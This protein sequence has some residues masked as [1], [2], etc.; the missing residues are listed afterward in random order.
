MALRLVRATSGGVGSVSPELS[1]VDPALA[2][3]VRGTPDAVVVGAAAETPDWHGAAR[4]ATP[5]TTTYDTRDLLLERHGLR[6][7]LVSDGPTRTWR[8]TAARGEVVETTSAGPGVPPEI[9]SLLTN[10]VVGAQLVRVPTRSID[11]DIRRLEDSIAQQ[12]HALVRHDVGVRIAS[13]PESLHQLRVA[14]RRIRTFL[15]VG[16]DLVD[17][18]WARELKSGMRELGRASTEARDLD[19][20]LEK[21]SDQIG[22]FDPRDRA[23]GETLLRTLEED[24]RALQHALVDL[25]DSGSHRRVL[26][27]LALPAVPAA[28]PP[29]RK[30]DKLAAR[31]LRRL[32]A[33]VRRLGKHPGDEQLHDL[34]IKVKR[35]RYATELGG[36]PADKRARRVVKAA[37]QLQDILGEHQDASVG[38][39]RL[40]QVAHR[41]DD[42]GVAF[43]AGRLAERER[44]RRG[45]IHR[46]L[47]PAWKKLRKLS[48]RS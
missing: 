36:A 28:A 44:I 24:R 37:T 33:R 12:Q 8:L 42:S 34:R 18:E 25:L 15:A 29:A 4:S 5:S 11:P 16:R 10:V 21:V 3:T 6:L 23:G 48:R 30:L 1:L 19:I 2:A 22:A 43:A 35:V 40:R 26:D 39:E 32:V 31:E 38:E 7:E 45:E 17:E 13:D 27:Q 47:P 9:E 46:R 41:Y 20:L 14:S